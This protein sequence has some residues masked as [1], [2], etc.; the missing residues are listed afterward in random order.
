[1]FWSACGSRVVTRAS[2]LPGSVATI[3]PVISS[4]IAKMSS[5]LRS[6]FSAH[7]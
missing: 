7:T 1:M 5:I 4:C 6:Y 2:I 3:A